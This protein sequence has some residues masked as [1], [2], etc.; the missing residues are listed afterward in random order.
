MTVLVVSG[1]EVGLPFLLQ[2]GAE[3]I[4]LSVTQHSAAMN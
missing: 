2:K 3:L 1:L 4:Q